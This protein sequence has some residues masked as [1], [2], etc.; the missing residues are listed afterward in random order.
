MKCTSPMYFLDRDKLPSDKWSTFDRYFNGRS[1]AYV[2]SSE[3]RDKYSFFLSTSF[4]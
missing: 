2:K 4:R 3:L 1:S